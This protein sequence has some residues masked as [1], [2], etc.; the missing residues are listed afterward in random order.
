MINISETTSSPTYLPTSSVEGQKLLSVEITKSIEEEGERVVDLVMDQLND[1]ITPS[2]M[3]FVPSEHNALTD[4]LRKK[5]KVLNNKLE[6]MIIKFVSKNRLTLI[7]ALPVQLV[8]M[9]DLNHYVPEVLGKTVGV[10]LANEG[11][12]GFV[13][14]HIGNVNE[15][16][17]LYHL[18][19]TALDIGSIVSKKLI[20]KQLTEDQKFAISIMAAGLAMTALEM[21]VGVTDPLDSFG[22]IVGLI[23]MTA[24]YKIIQNWPVIQ[25]NI[26]NVTANT[27]INQALSK[28]TSE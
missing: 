24:A 22:T 17:I 6:D 16:I 8:T 5:S 9:R 27:K 11:I 7:N 21:N 26:K 10:P 25:Q 18:F 3:L 20:E 19:S 14:Q 4:N 23:Y 2:R 1:V 15:V 28:E 12:A 13:D